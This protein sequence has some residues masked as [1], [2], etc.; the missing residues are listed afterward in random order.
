LDYR[1]RVKQLKQSQKV[2][3][4]QKAS[5]FAKITGK[6]GGPRCLV[7]ENRSPFEARDVKVLVNGEPFP[8]SLRV[9]TA[10]ANQDVSRIAPGQQIEFPLLVS[11]ALN[12]YIA[13]FK[14]VR[15][16]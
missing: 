7:I 15:Y 1:G 16:N 11:N 6:P 2:K 13:F 8:G 4:S 9:A 3:Q 10:F 5:L 14:P 12:T